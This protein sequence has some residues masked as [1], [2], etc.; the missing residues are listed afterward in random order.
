M[1]A[2]IKQL[3]KDGLVSTGGLPLS[4]P[5]A[6]KTTLTTPNLSEITYICHNL[7]EDEKD[8]FLAISGEDE[9]DADE[10]A[11]IT[12]SAPGSVPIGWYQTSTHYRAP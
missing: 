3:N 9:F 2:A 12:Y 1:S 5:K 8:Q 4:K 6:P 7:P 11:V 10:A